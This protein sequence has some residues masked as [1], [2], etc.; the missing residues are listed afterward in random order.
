MISNFILLSDSILIPSKDSSA[1]SCFFIQTKGGI[2][3]FMIMSMAKS[4][5]H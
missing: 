3:L 2:Y 4:A 5:S 1:F